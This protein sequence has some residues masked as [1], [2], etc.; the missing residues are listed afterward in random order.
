MSTVK[1]KCKVVM[2]PTNEVT[3]IELNHQNNE[4]G[5]FMGFSDNY[6]KSKY[7]PNHERSFKEF[8]HLYIISDDEIKEGDRYIDDADTIRQS[9][10]SD[11]EYWERRKDYKKI[12]ATTDNSLKTGDWM[13]ND[14]LIP[15]PQPSPEFIQKYIQEYN[16]GNEIEEVLIEYEKTDFTPELVG[17]LWDG[18]SYNYK[19]KL[20]IDK[21]N[22]ITITKYKDSWSREEVKILLFN[23]NSDFM[24]ASLENKEFNIKDWIQEYL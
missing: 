24:L 11:K 4:L 2:L 1:R 10:T 3:K 12:I 13:H 23:S 5:Y 7:I 15:L 21:N 17:G 19:L 20:K 14:A 9:V 16:K 8:Q 22:N 18:S 6:D